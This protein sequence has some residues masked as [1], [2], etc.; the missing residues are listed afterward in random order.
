MRTAKLLLTAAAS[1]LPFVGC[2]A[3]PTIGA[4]DMEWL[5]QLSG[6]DEGP[7][8]QVVAMWTDAS[9]RKPGAAGVTR[10][11]G[12]RLY[13]YDAK[14]HPVKA[15]GEL[16]V[17]AFVE[18]DRQA[19][20]KLPERKFIFTAEELEQNYS[21]TALG[22]CYDV[23]LPW[24]K[25]E[26]QTVSVSLLPTLKMADGKVVLGSQSLNVLKGKEVEGEDGLKI[27]A[28]EGVR[29]VSYHEDAE[30]TG[31]GK[32]SRR[33]MSIYDPQTNV[34]VGPTDL[35][36]G[37]IPGPDPGAAHVGFDSDLPL[38]TGISTTTFDLPKSMAMAIKT[39][40]SNYGAKQ[41]LSD[42]FHAS[43]AAERNMPTA[44]LNA[45]ANGVTFD[46]SQAAALDRRSK[47]SSKSQAQADAQSLARLIAANAGG[48]PSVGVTPNASEAKAEKKPPGR[49]SSEP[50][51]TPAWT[52]NHA[53]WR[54]EE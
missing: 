49:F 20:S 22:H 53:S 36:A 26:D 47:T 39:A 1:L 30:S 3:L 18:K 16:V 12:G 34:T 48:M 24:G 40:P 2:T 21:K 8:K 7:P 43:Q 33:R 46:L 52:R 6:N 17:Y 10:G 15:E 50:R 19:P 42:R 27:T 14:Q 51:R 45:P 41:G 5:S 23:W 44:G 54:Q 4:P 32:S 31:D 9:M 25:D 37:P 35:P 11:F 29:Q 28:S 13:F 38:A